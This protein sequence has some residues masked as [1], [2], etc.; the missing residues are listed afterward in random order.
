MPWPQ[1]LAQA[2]V[3]ATFLG[4][5]IALAAYFNGKHIKETV[6]KIDEMMENLSRI[7]QKMDER[8]ATRED[9]RD[10]R[11]ETS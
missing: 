6:A 5:G 3:M 4:V 2:A 8:L 1:I 7:R 9:G 10:G 11:R